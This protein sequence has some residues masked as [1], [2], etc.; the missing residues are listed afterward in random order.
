LRSATRRG[1]NQ[2]VPDSLEAVRKDRNH[3]ASRASGMTPEATATIVLTTSS[4]DVSIE[5]PSCKLLDWQELEERL[6][7]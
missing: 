1:R 3:F 2:L 7:S 6:D 4:S 5:Y